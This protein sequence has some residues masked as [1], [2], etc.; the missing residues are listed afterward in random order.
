MCTRQFSQR[1]IK[2]ALHFESD[3][4][5]QTIKYYNLNGTVPVDK[6]K[7]PTKL[8]ITLNKSQIQPQNVNDLRFVIQQVWDDIKQETIK[9]LVQSFL[10]RLQLI[11]DNNGESIQPFL[12]SDLS[13]AQLVVHP[14][15]KI[16]ELDEIVYIIVCKKRVNI[17][18]R[19]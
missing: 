11:I 4:I 9:K 16:T 19:Q 2:K 5:S 14:I 7:K 13:Q 6:T 17:S 15:G 8:T 3:K 12:R 1:L 10:Q 18:S